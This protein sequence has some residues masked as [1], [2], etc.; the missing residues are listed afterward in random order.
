MTIQNTH[1]VNTHKETTTGQLVLDSLWK[2]AKHHKVSYQKIKQLN[3]GK[4]AG[5]GL[6]A[7]EQR[8]PPYGV[9]DGDIILLSPPISIERN[10]QTG[11]LVV[12]D[13]L[14]DLPV[15][16]DAEVGDPFERC[17]DITL[18]V[19]VL[20]IRYAIAKVSEAATMPSASPRKQLDQQFPTIKTARYIL[21]LLREGL[22]YLYIDGQMEIYQHSN[23]HFSPFTD[24]Q[25]RTD[26]KSPLTQSAG[27]YLLIPENKSVY[28]AFSEHQWTAWQYYKIACNI[29]GARDQQMQRLTTN[30]S[31]Q[32]NTLPL[33]QLE[34][35]VMDFIGAADGFP[36]SDTPVK[37]PHYAAP[38]QQEMTEHIHQQVV[39]LH[40]PIAIVHDFSA[41]L[42]Q[43]LDELQTYTTSPEQGSRDGEQRFR[44]KIISDIIEGLY[45]SGFNAE[46]NL[47]ARESNTEARQTPG[48]IAVNRKQ[49]HDANDV[50]IHHRP[51]RSV[52]QFSYEV[53]LEEQFNPRGRALSQFIDEYAR[54][55]FAENYK[56][57]VQQFQ[58]RL[59]NIKQDRH[60][61]LSQWDKTDDPSTLGTAWSSYDMH[62]LDDWNQYGL[63]VTR[64]STLIAGCGLPAALKQQD[65]EPILFNRW[66]TAG[67]DTPVHLALSGFPELRQAV[68]KIQLNPAIKQQMQ[69]SDNGYFPQ[70]THL[71]DREAAG[72]D[73]LATLIDTIYTKFPLIGT[74]Q[75][76]LVTNVTTA[77][78]SNLQLKGHPMTQINKALD[79]I[80]NNQNIELLWKTI[81][82]RGGHYNL[83]V[84]DIPVEKVIQ[85]IKGTADKIG[86][87]FST[88][89]LSSNDIVGLKKTT[90]DGQPAAKATSHIRLFT[91]TD[92]AYSYKSATLGDARP[93]PFGG[94]ASGAVS[95]FVLHLTFLNLHSAL[96]T[97]DRNEFQESTS[98]IGAALMAIGSATNGLLMALKSAAPV[99]YR[100]ITAYMIVNRLAR[101]SAL[102]VFGYLGA[103][104]SG[105][106]DAIRSNKRFTAGDADAGSYYALSA[107]TVLAGGSAMTHGAVLL[108]TGAGAAIPV[109]GWLVL[110]I[111]LV[112]VSIW[113][114]TEALDS[115]DGPLELWLDAC[116][117]GR[118]QLP[119][120]PPYS[121]LIEEQQAYIKKMLQPQLISKELSRSDT[122]WQAKEYTAALELYLPSYANSSKLSVS[123]D[124]EQTNS[125]IAGIRTAEQPMPS[126]ELSAHLQGVKALYEVTI[127]LRPLS[128]I[129]F[130]VNYQASP[131]SGEAIQQTYTALAQQ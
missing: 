112:G 24:A 13:P 12:N 96:T 14:A 21:R 49:H 17:P 32:H 68:L 48:S 117:F 53:L 1:T 72:T 18:M 47:Q 111:S 82:A 23:G 11:A 77:A 97:F 67:V 29:D 64:A 78:F 115:T 54:R 91:I 80:V 33:S 60:L 108:V 8:Q 59:F 86:M 22:V 50:R 95:V 6:S 20:P 105:L 109:I 120:N 4:G 110:G 28:F 41:L 10:T 42:E 26:A 52:E 44:K 114:T 5:N 25:A 87:S 126:P 27:G 16:R 15:F 123:Y 107:A 83:K 70:A 31:A 46:Q 40:D 74:L 3:K 121:N 7:Y 55:K 88:Q 30:G 92:E 85:Y 102:R 122:F 9:Q 127:A 43:Q 99:F 118:K 98:N 37:G 69:S 34:Q 65:Q 36:W 106:T 35:Q 131:N 38:L 84:E 73:S 116:I 79:G 71:W 75:Q 128:E 66:L 89:N 104:L 129:H 63:S 100:K 90:V 124:F 94:Y 103:I 113:A 76:E 56:Q 93:N 81:Q 61:W 130:T 2:I 101:T 62:D 39:A 119:N 19:A 45:R 51:P 58:T 57:Q 125:A